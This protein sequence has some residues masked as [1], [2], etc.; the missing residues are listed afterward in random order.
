MPSDVVASGPLGSHSSVPSTASGRPTPSSSCRAWATAPPVTAAS[1]CNA[2]LSRSDR[3]ARATVAACGSASPRW[4]SAAVQAGR[5]A[6]QHQRADHRAGR[7]GPDLQVRQSGRGQR[8]GVRR[9]DRPVHRQHVQVSA[10]LAGRR[11]RSDLRIV[12]TKQ[13]GQQV[14]VG[15]RGST[16]AGS[17][18]RRRSAGASGQVRRLN[19]AVRT[20][21][22]MPDPGPGEQRRDVDGQAG[23]ADD[24]DHTV[25]ARGQHAIGGHRTESV[26][27][28]SPFGGEPNH[29]PTGRKSTDQADLDQPADHVQPDLWIG[30]VGQQHIAQR[31]GA[32]QGAE[33]SHPLRGRSG[34]QEGA[35]G[36]GAD[37]QPVRPTIDHQDAAGQAVD[38]RGISAGGGGRTSGHP[39]SVTRR[40]RRS[41][42]CPQRPGTPTA[43]G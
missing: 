28:R 2:G 14:G 19:G 32:V 6:R 40:R 22:D 29:R 41:A 24:D 36:I 8:R 21:V 42:S 23:G 26:G 34:E 16:P 43:P 35:W 5:T 3:R 15:N 4:R 33:Q 39:V 37:L 38:R 1:R 10:G 11:F 9:I 12:S 25:L 20:V 30:P 27:E 18:G 17:P 31:G 7:S 13:S